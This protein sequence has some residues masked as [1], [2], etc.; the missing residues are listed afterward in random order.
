M[1]ITDAWPCFVDTSSFDLFQCH[2]EQTQAAALPNN[3]ALRSPKLTKVLGG[4][5]MGYG[6]N[7][8]I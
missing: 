5:N 2:A 8:L 7:M 1:F 6:C 3:G 4:G